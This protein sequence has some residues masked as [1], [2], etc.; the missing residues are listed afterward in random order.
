M[1]QDLTTTPTQAELDRIDADGGGANIVHPGSEHSSTPRV[2]ADD[3]EPVSRF[4]PFE[5]SL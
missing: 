4:D 5:G 2:I 1:S 3:Q